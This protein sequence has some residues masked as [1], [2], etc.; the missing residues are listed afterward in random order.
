MPVERGSVR[1]VTLYDDEHGF[2]PNYVTSLLAMI[3]HDL[4]G[5]QRI[6]RGGWTLKHAKSYDIAAAR[7]EATTEFLESDVEWMLF[8]D[9]DMGWDADALDRLFDSADAKQRPIV[10]GLCFGYSPVETGAAEANGP[11]RYPFPTLYWFN[12]TDTDIG[13][14]IM[15]NYR[16]GALNVVKAT[17][18]A[19]L[20]IHRSAL[21]KMFEK[22]GATWWSRIKHPK[23]QSMW[24]ED[25]SFCA[26]AG[27]CEIPI[28][29]DTRVRTSH[30]KPI[31]VSEVTFSSG[32]QAPP[33]DE[34]IDVIVPVM[35]RPDHA[36][37][38]MRSLRAS[39]GLARVTAVATEDDIEAIDAWR[40]AG[41]DVCIVDPERTTFA[42]KVNDAFDYLTDDPRDWV[43]LVGS[44]VLFRSAWWDHALSVARSHGASVVATNDLLNDDVRNGRLAT[45]PVMRRAYI[46]EHGAS[47][48]GPGV[49]AHEGYSHWYVDAEW[50]TVALQ[51]GVLSTSLS[52]VV[53]HIHPII[54]KAPMDAVYEL[55]Q[56]H[57]KADAALFA[58]RCKRFANKAAA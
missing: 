56:K 46:E 50:S 42:M 4:V 41:A 6:A 28:F 23:A 10:G 38:F 25:T 20:L 40:A 19:F 16:A 14:Q 57:R 11:F 24:G 30:L 2:S 21:E 8:V 1:I 52:S 36:A 13:F 34:E 54:G 47:W 26:R 51:R 45:H 55:G 44:D 53:E 5:E 3:G 12:E 29:V 9:S 15:W 32:I 35:G 7:N 37:P 33:A 58:A 48:D 18:A 17:G 22:H 31:Y 49:I 27:L 43:L 39:T